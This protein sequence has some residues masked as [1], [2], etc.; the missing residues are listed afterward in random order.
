MPAIN[1]GV[2]VPNSGLLA[3][4]EHITAIAQRAEAAGLDSLWV[5][6]HIAMPVEVTPRYP[7]TDDG[8]FPIPTAG[9]P[10]LDPFNVL[11]F[12]AA[13]TQRVRLGTSVIIVPY[14]HPLVLAK[15]ITT[16][17]VLSQGRVVFGI[18]VGWCIE[19]FE[20][21]NQS[22]AQRG[23]V[24][25]ESLR[26]M[27]QLWREET[28]S[29]EGQFFRFP[30]LGFL[31]KPVQQPHPPIVVGGESNVALRR[32]VEFGNGWHPAGNIAP[33]FL[34]QRLDALEPRLQA[35][36]RRLSD[37]EIIVRPLGKM[38]INEANLEAWREAGVHTIVA[39]IPAS[40]I[41]AVFARMDRLAELRRF[42]AERLT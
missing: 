28:P 30:P 16:L 24:T 6:D 19:E 31:P 39:D 1:I 17:D 36:G 32:V 26:L 34:R 4:P 9:W 23:A 38:S 13:V 33:A 14:R 3:L 5:G 7:Y 42:C 8:A 10:W 15:H 35:A 12:A 29:F 21:L 27:H 2:T 22:Y 11:T 20:V 40:S 37:L 18:G 25:S 41:D